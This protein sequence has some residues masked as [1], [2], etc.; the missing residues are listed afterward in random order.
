MPTSRPNRRLMKS[1]MLSSCLISFFVNASLKIT[2]SSDLENG[3]DF[4]SIPSVPIQGRITN[5][6]K[7]IHYIKEI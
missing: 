7:I 4:F 1:C 2:D 5:N 6:F 3:E